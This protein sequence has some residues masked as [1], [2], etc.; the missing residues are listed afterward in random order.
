MTKP[1]YQQYHIDVPL[2][3]LSVAYNPG[4]YIAAEVF[5]NVPVLTISG[6]Y[7][8]YSKGD[9]LRR[10]AKPRAPGT[11]A[12]RGGYSLTTAN[13]LTTETAFATPVT[14]EQ[15][16]NSTDPL[17]PLTDGTQFVTRQ[18]LAEMESQ[19]AATAFG[20]SVW[21][22]SATPS[23]L[24]NLANSTPIEDVESGFSSIV[25]S[26]GMMPN[27]AVVGYQVFSALK[28]HPDILDRIKGMASPT[29]PAVV[30]AN[31]I[32]A[33][34]NVDALLV[35]IQIENTGAEGATDTTAYIWGKHLLLAYVAAGASLMTPSAGYVA[36]YLNRV[37]ERYR[38][39]Q[40]KQDVIA[41]YWNFDVVTT[42]T[43]AGYLFKSAVA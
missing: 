42:A 26:I 24:W 18:L 35:G 3:N 14:D 12:V 29:S 2:T 38:E 25:S 4:G 30:T 23:A 8:I 17:Q 21:S 32:A 31:A 28:N 41:G 22:G 13:Y 1:T 43:D 16:R 40:E 19:V 9:W 11:R 5:P 37:I 6:K 7:F 15:V 36:T 39:D 27:K 20:N 34:F 10:E 33:L